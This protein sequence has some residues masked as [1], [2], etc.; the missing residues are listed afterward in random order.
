MD[1]NGQI[2]SSI[3]PP[4]AVKPDVRIGQ[5]K[6]ATDPKRSLIIAREFF[7]GKIARSIQVLDWL[8]QRYDIE[9]ELHITKHEAAKLGG[10]STVPQLRTV[11][12]RVALRYWEAFRKV[13]PERLDFKFRGFDSRNRHAGD[14]VNAAL[15]YGYGFLEGVCR[16]AVNSIG[17]EPAVGFSH[18]LDE[19]RTKQSMTL[20]L[21]EPYRF[22]VDLTVMKAFEADLLTPHDF[23]YDR[24]DYRFQIQTDGR[25][26]FRQALIETFN[27]RISYKGRMCTWDFVIEEKANELARYLTGRSSSISF[28]EPAP[29]LER[30]D[31][32]AMRERILSL[33]QSEAEKIGI[34]K[35]TLHYLRKKAKRRE[36]FRVYLKVREKL[37]HA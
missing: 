2:I 28:S 33:S 6:A 14:C 29:T 25:R 12:G 37:Q 26:R 27:N 11:E 20:D 4:S 10:A 8:A 19:W 36:P 32:K 3:L 23:G 21:M 9:R 7:K 13:I 31:N 22:L 24:D 1:Y 35:S 17:L 34:E 5:I 30:Q 15:N 18:S 16:K